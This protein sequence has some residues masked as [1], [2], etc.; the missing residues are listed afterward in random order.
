MPYKR[1]KGHILVD[2]DI[3]DII[4]EE[5]SGTEIPKWKIME[6][7]CNTSEHF[8]KLKKRWGKNGGTN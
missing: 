5:H 8:A 7:I 6:D 4:H 3:Y 2:Q 1:A